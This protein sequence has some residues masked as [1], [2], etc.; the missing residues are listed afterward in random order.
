MDAY[1]KI[2]AYALFAIVGL[3]VGSFLN[4]V[5]YRLPNKMNLAFPASHCTTCDYTLKWYDNI[6][7]LSY[8]ILGGKCRSCK[9]RISPRY[10]LVEIVNA[11]LWTLSVFVFWDSS[12]EG[13]I[14]AVTAAVISSVLVCIFFI[15]LEHMIIFNRFTVIIAISGLATMFT[16]GFTKWYDH[17]IGAL[18]GG[19]VFLAI[20]FGAILI[21]KREGLGFGDV[22]LAAAAGFMLGWQKLILAILLASVVASVVLL[23]LKAI[24][25]DEKNKE[26]P[27]GPFISAGVLVA[28]FFGAPLINWYL[29]LI[30]G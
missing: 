18:V 19:G 12:A 17:I 28:M 14:Y 1:I 11:L 3:C 4:V 13:R 2:V 6:P 15:D 23:L 26:Y 29:G 9:Q 25:K 21:I 22:K 16:D 7:V 27:F 8:V 24:R 20:Y 5:I 30:L 10:M